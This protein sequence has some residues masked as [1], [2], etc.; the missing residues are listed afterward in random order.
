[1]LNVD[2]TK[3]FLHDIL[4]ANR[5]P[6]FFVFPDAWLCVP[7][8][9]NVNVMYLD[10]YSFCGKKV[11]VSTSCEHFMTFSFLFSPFYAIHVYKYSG[12]Y[13]MRSYE[14][15]IK[16]RNVSSSVNHEAQVGGEGSFTIISTTYIMNIPAKNQ[17]CII[18]LIRYLTF[19]IPIVICSYLLRFNKRAMISE[20][21][22]FCSRSSH[23]SSP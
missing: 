12:S 4:G 5:R 9:L 11:T 18:Q 21:Q 17:L 22:Y 7:H 10:S 8:M 6:I 15:K 23:S 19:Y 14:Q 20:R 2:T 16:N 13:C 1:M 3:T